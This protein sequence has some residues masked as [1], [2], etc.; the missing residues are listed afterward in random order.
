[1]K[2]STTTYFSIQY[3]TFTLNT[4][5]GNYKPKFIWNI[6]HSK[7]NSMFMMTKYM[8]SSYKNGRL[9]I[10]AKSRKTRF[11]RS[12][13]TAVASGKKSVLVKISVS[14]SHTAVTGANKERSHGLLDM[15]V[16]CF[17]VFQSHRIYTR[18]K[19]KQ[20]HL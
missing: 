15:L 17:R 18:G 13:A 6:R 1:M 2:R 8:Y 10:V 12:S 19:K 20:F 5:K 3:Y 16:F 14:D 11:S 7:T 9:I 4:N